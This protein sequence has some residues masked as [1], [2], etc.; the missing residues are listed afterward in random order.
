MGSIVQIDKIP[1]NIRS[2]VKTGLGFALKKGI[3]GQTPI[4]FV[5]I[6]NSLSG[7]RTGAAVFVARYGISDKNN[8]DSKEESSGSTFIRVLKITLKDDC[9]SEKEGY[10]KTREILL[11]I[12]S[13][14]E[15][16]SQDEFT[17]QDKEYG[18]L[19][20]QDVGAVA[21]S[22][23]KGVT[24]FLTKKILKSNNSEEAEKF[25][26]ELSLLL[27][28]EVF[29]GLKKGLYGRL[30]R[31][32][33]NFLE[34]YGKKISL[35]VQDEIDKLKKIDRN[36][37]NSSTIVDFFNFNSSYHQVNYIHGDLNPENILV[38]ENER[39][40]LNCKLIDFGEVVPKKKEN[41]TPLFWDFSRLMGELILN[42][43][44]DTLL[45]SKDEN[46]EIIVHIQEIDQFLIEFWSIL[47]AF[48]Q[49]DSSKLDNASSQIGF[50]SR[51]YLSTLF[52][53]INE[54]KSGIKDLRRAEVLQDYFF[55]KLAFCFFMQ[56]FKEKILIRESS[57]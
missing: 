49:N 17:F 19:L 5:Q 26:R 18:I 57:V 12:F 30:Q 46:K 2:L 43:V 20:Y 3:L 27:Q 23:L 13:E 29:L 6:E 7:G 42:F 38:W 37:P 33:L 9:L 15:Y 40:F 35:N 25:S 32:E 53:F 22:D 55:V 48:F 36:L 10:V 24:D 45:T 28:K 34:F 56:S 16:Y 47:E 8:S 39:G 31:K 1:N 51:I 21:T 4:D 41:F 52:D 11:D 44:E 54:A 50:I 14:V